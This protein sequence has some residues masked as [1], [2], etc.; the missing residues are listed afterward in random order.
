[1]PEFS[2]I[3]RAKEIGVDSFWYKD[4]NKETILAVMDRTMQGENI[5]PDNTPCI[6]LGYTTNHDLTERE[7][8]ILKAMM[9]GDSNAQIAERNYKIFKWFSRYKNNHKQSTNF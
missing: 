7:L 1:M 6:K 4:V 8:Q 9:L 3:K 2:W 5:Y